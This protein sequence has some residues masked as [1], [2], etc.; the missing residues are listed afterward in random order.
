[1]ACSFKNKEIT[2]IC[3]AGTITAMAGAADFASS[4]YFIDKTPDDYTFADK[5]NPTPWK[6]FSICMGSVT[7][8]TTVF[9]EGISTY[10]YI[11]RKIIFSA[12]RES[13]SAQKITFKNNR[14]PFSYRG[15]I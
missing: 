9:T 10:K 4:Y 15:S 13:A 2:S 3:L 5:I 14:L 6:I 7:A 1:M 11:R 12:F 8:F